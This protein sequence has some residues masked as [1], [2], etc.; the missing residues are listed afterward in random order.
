MIERV[1][2]RRH[3]VNRREKIKLSEAGFRERI[4]LVAWGGYY[5]LLGKEG[6]RWTSSTTFSRGFGPGTT[7]N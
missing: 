6:N 5:Q 2:D 3:A 1:T 7:T 4:T